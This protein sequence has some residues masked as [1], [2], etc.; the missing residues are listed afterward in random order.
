MKLI[1]YLLTT[2]VLTLSMTSFAETRYISD[3]VYIYMHSGPSL[4][5][6]IIGTL[7]VGTK[8]NTLKYDEKTKFMQIKTEKGKVGWMKVAELQKTLPA[9]NL[10]PVL[11][12]ELDDAQ[13]ALKNIS[14]KNAIKLSEKELVIQEQVALVS[15][16]KVETARLKA[17]VVNLKSRKLELELWQETRESQ[18]K[19]NWML[20]GGGFLLLGLL[21]GLMIP[22][23]PRRKKRSNNW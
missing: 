6:R 14:D 5:Y 7:K 19:M 18:E 3:D 13:L 2:F 11:K 8:V 12:K 1:K 9:K 21:I 17:D 16:L 20:E 4:E 22:F 15:E 23:L 10:L